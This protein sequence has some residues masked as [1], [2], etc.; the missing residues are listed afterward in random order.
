MCC[1]ARCVSG[2]ARAAVTGTARPGPRFRPTTTSSRRWLT[3]GGLTV[4]KAGEQLARRGV[5]V[6]ERTLHSYAL[7]VLGV[8]RSVRGT[9]VREPSW[10]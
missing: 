8:G 1:S 7:E 6:P 4:V 3:E 5:L 9:T 10:M 2:C